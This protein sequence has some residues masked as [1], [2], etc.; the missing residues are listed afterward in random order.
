MIHSASLLGQTFRPPTDQGF[1]SM[2]GAD[3]QVGGVAG[4]DLSMT[5][6]TRI[7]RVSRVRRSRFRWEDAL[8]RRPT[9]T[10]FRRGTVLGPAERTGSGVSTTC[11][12]STPST[13]ASERSSPQDPQWIGRWSTISP[14]SCRIERFDPG[15]P[16]CL[17]RRRS[18][19][20]LRFAFASARRSTR[21]LVTSTLVLRRVG[22]RRR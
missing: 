18:M 22:R 8:R 16:L 21:V 12:R 13:G 2:L 9:R 5:A 14:G 6:R 10:T 19:S 1:L 17:P 11:L 15:A 7:G 20:S 3:G 4:V